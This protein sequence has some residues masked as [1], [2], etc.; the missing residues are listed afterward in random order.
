M[1]N[2]NYNLVRITVYIFQI[3]QWSSA[4]VID[5]RSNF[6]I[7]NCSASADYENCSFGHCLHKRIHFIVKEGLNERIIYS[8]GP[9]S[10]WALIVLTN[11]EDF[12]PDLYAHQ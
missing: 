4:S 6:T 1:S 3:Q 9:L 10:L 8:D 12:P 11:F 5:Q 2:I 7:V